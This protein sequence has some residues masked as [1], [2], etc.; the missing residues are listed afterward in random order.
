MTT[1]KK[2]AAIPFSEHAL[3]TVVADYMTLMVRPELYWSAIPNGGKRNLSVAV[4]LKRE[5]LKRGSPDLY[6]M[7]PEGKIAWLELKVKGGS[8][9]L[10]QRMFRDVCNRL[11]HHWAVAK[12]LDDVI[13]F[14]QK[15]GALK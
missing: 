5:G 1:I 3:Q 12:S 10:E 15:I 14:L 13:A 8:L 6:V 11:G 2:R 9:S 7:L 4:K